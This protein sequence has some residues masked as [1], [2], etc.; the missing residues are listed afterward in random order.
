MSFEILT[1]QPIKFYE[2]NGIKVFDKFNAVDNCK[3]LLNVSFDP[4]DTTI[5]AKD[6]K[7]NLSAY[8]LNFNIPKREMVGVTLVAEPPK[9]GIGEVLTLSAL[10]EFVQNNLNYFKTFSLKESIQFHARFGFNLV[11]ND[12][13]EILHHLKMVLKSRSPKYENLRYDANFYYPKLSGKVKNDDEFI[14]SRACHVA[15]KYLQE[16]SK[17]RVKIDPSN[18][19]YS[20]HMLFTDYETLTNKD[21]L[22]TLLDKHE[23]NYKF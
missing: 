10:M 4:T 7:K 12:V 17:D 1:R 23:I 6:L 22:N 8:T 15:S 13:D 2:K 11:T 19:R 14:N 16:L 3:N 20:S 21:Y 9:K 5:Y 18:F